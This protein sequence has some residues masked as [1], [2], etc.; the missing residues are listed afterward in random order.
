M[1]RF[2]SQR[3]ELL[4]YI[5]VLMHYSGHFMS[6]IGEKGVVNKALS[7]SGLFLILVIF[8]TS[9]LK[10]QF[11]GAIS[12]WISFFLLYSFTI[13]IRIGDIDFLDLTNPDNLR[14]IFFDGRYTL[15]YFIPFFSLLGFNTFTFRNLTIICIIQIFVSLL[16]SVIYFPYI[17][18]S[19]ESDYS[20]WIVEYMGLLVIPSGIVL[21]TGRYSN[22]WLITII[23]MGIFLCVFFA[24]WRGRR[25]VTAIPAMI[26]ILYILSIIKNKNSIISKF[27]VILIVF[28]IGIKLYEKVYNNEDSL[29]SQRIDTDNRSPEDRDVIASLDGFDLF[30]GKGLN[31]MYFSKAYQFER[32]ICESGTHHMLLKGG[33]FFLLLYYLI[34]IL[35]FTSGIKAKNKFVKGCSLYIALMSFALYPLGSP[36]LSIQYVVLWFCII[37]CNNSQLKNK[38]DKEIKL[39]FK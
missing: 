31:G 2:I 35:S 7:A 5:A 20:A 11:K 30:F 28:Q 37:V 1:V 12:F 10:W 34:L 38:D 3:K 25:S 23:V 24:I 33:V 16:M 15:G 17:L 4:L 13:V 26:L 36:V 29:L 27:F 6:V 18:M 32:G 22:K 39:Y 19:L 8:A 21:L 14:S 9:R